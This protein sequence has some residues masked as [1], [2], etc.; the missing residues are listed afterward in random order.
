M[1]PRAGGEVV[2]VKFQ[3]GDFVKE[4][5]L[6]FEI[7]PRPYQS[8]VKRAE[9]ALARDT[10]TL[11]Q[12]EANLARDLAQ[13][14]Y[15]KAQVARYKKLFE[16]GVVAR[17]QYEE[18]MA[19][20][21]A[22]TEVIKA[23]RA[24]IDSAREIIRADNGALE[25]AKLDLSFCSIHA[26]LTGHTG[27]LAVRQGAVVKINE[28]DLVTV[29]QVQ[30]IYVTFAVPESALPEVKRRM[31]SGKIQVAATPSDGGGPESGVLTFTDNEIGRAHV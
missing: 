27:N 21:E 17:E 15:P 10:A 24:A 20:A 9:A 12:L 2:A 18:V 11:K 28:A 25:G 26:P 14:T 4:G 16:E 5:D 30:P 8:A 13:E 31:A 1:R 23:S 29:N 7:D 22:Q 6:L 3:E 19:R